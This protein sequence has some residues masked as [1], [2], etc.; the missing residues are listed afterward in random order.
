MSN[1]SPSQTG[2]DRE[3]GVAMTLDRLGH[4]RV[5]VAPDYQSL[6]VA[7]AE[8]IAHL[9]QVKPDAVL[10]LATGSTPIGIYQE[11]VRLHQQIGLDFSGIT[12][13]N[14]DEYYPMDPGDDHSYHTFMQQHLFGS[15]NCRNWQ[16]PDGRERSLETIAEDCRRY[17]EA[18]EKAG[19]I[20]LQILG[21]GST[22]H[23]GFNEPGSAPDSKTRLVDLDE[24][25]RLNA[26]RDFGRLEH[27]P[28][29]AVT[30]GIS[31]IL[32]SREIMLIAS[33]AGKAAIVYTALN[34]LVTPLVPASLLQNH[35][36]ASFWL[37]SAAAQ[38]LEN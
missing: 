30:M 31:T 16:V 29:Q 24:S 21:I 23:I 34:V 35:P 20:D 5:H 28:H 3:P 25:T 9:V 7:V 11:L 6:C 38:A 8:R 26:A 13:F 17:E 19:G 33:G 2:A 10:G 36:N 32:K 18:I 4:P 37:D 27:V 14:L 1:P 12:C 22:G 15:I